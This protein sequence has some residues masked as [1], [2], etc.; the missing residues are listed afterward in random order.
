MIYLTSWSYHF[1]LFRCYLGICRWGKPTSVR[2]S[3][4][5]KFPSA[6]KNRWFN[7]INLRKSFR[8][9]LVSKRTKMIFWTLTHVRF[10]QLWASMAVLVP[11]LSCSHTRQPRQHSGPV[12][13]LLLWCPLISLTLS[14]HTFLEFY[15]PWDF[16]LLMTSI[17]GCSQMAALVA[18]AT[19]PIQAAKSA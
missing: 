9:S 16:L 7:E 19:L 12:S 8:S 6:S 14:V 5:T 17:Y 1:N 11:E 10:W 13:I 18:G 3:I 15:V 2:L 4:V